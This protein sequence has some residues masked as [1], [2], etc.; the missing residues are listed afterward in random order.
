MEKWGKMKDNI[1]ITGISGISLA[2]RGK[3]K[4]LNTPE[5]YP[6][7]GIEVMKFLG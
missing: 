4:V 6:F 3:V 5:T 1:L 7:L 2:K